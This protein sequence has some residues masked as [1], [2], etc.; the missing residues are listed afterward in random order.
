[1]SGSQSRG[2]G[3]LLTAALLS[4]PLLVPAQAIPP[5]APASPGTPAQETGASALG[6]T[7]RAL[8]ALLAAP[9]GPPPA[10]VQIQQSNVDLAEAIRRGP[11]GEPPADT[12]LRLHGLLVHHHH[13]EASLRTPFFA[14]AADA[15]PPGVGSALR[16]VAAPHAVN[17]TRIDDAIRRLRELPP[18][19]R[20]D[21][22]RLLVAFETYQDRTRNL[23]LQPE[24]LRHDGLPLLAGQTPDVLRANA[25]S[26][27]SATRVADALP[28]G[29]IHTVPR[30]DGLGPVLEARHRLLERTLHLEADL[31]AHPDPPGLEVRLPPVLA[32]DLTP[33]NDTYTDPYALQLDVGG[34]DVYRNNAG[35]SRLHPVECDEFVGVDAL[36]QAGGAAFL[37]DFAGDDTYGNTSDPQR[38]G[39]NGGAYHGSGALVDLG[40]SDK[41][42]AGNFANGAASTGTGLVLDVAGDDDFLGRAVT[43]GYANLGAVGAL[44][45]LAGD[46]TYRD[47]GNGGGNLGGSG[48]LIDLMGSDTYQGISAANGGAFFGG[49]GF[50]FDGAGDDVYDVEGGLGSNGGAFGALV[51]TVGFLFDGAGEDL[52]V[53][54]EA[55]DGVNGGADGLQ[56]LGTLVDVGGDDRYE[57]AGRGANGGA[58]AGGSGLLVDGAGDDVYRAGFRGS[59]GGT[60][61]QGGGSVNGTGLLWDGGGRDRYEDPRVA[62]WDCSVVPK[63]DV[64]AQV[65][66]GTG[67]LGVVLQV[68]G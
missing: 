38:C 66:A 53:G 26:T 18:D 58:D 25:S 8:E 7:D 4:V 10:A 12:A 67:V 45:D 29:A 21:L 14:S 62:C 5:P 24:A 48:H 16:G 57:A 34:D 2:A 13:P 15:S 6:A 23:T 20:S 63:G 47:G 17:E 46:D 30:L 51:R 33:G 40:G 37:A 52:Y 28:T 9:G 44:V 43:N 60:W 31:E 54:P 41:Y 11:D 39:V 36:L 61:Q 27:P 32:L 35:G 42:V 56:A 22:T 68:L 65:D 50:L 59:N 64:G 55:E 49:E 1:M 19:L 3:V